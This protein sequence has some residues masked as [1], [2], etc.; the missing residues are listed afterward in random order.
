MKDCIHAI[1]LSFSLFKAELVV[2]VVIIFFSS[3]A[4]VW[5]VRQN[6]VPLS[7]AMRLYTTVYLGILI[8]W[9]VY[10][11]W[12]QKHIPRNDFRIKVVA[13]IFV[14]IIFTS[15][16]TGVSLGSLI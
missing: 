3:L 2:S 1:K 11:L 5:L 4:L 12:I 13:M 16:M 9:P 15:A 10:L 14:L 7:L 8:A 6:Y